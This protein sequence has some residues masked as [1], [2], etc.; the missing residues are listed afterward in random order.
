[1]VQ[2]KQLRLRA[3]LSQR[4]VAERVGVSQPHYQRW[5]TG[6]AEVPAEK[7]KRLALVL[8]AK[9]EQI[10]TKHMPKQVH[11][12]PLE[13]DKVP[14]DQSYYGEVSVH[15]RSGK[16]LVLSISEAA[17]SKIYRDMQGGGH[18]VCV[19]SL[20]NQ[21]VAI[22]REAITDLHLMSEA[23]DTYGPEHDDYDDSNMLLQLIDDR[24]W[25]IIERMEWDDNLEEEFDKDEV[26]RVAEILKC[27]TDDEFANLVAY[28]RIQPEDV[29]DYKANEAAKL[30]TIFNFSRNVRY[31]FSTGKLRTLSVDD[32]EALYDAT[33]AIF[34]DLFDKDDPFVRLPMA[35]GYH[36]V[37]FINLTTVDYISVPNHRFMR[38][39]YEALEKEIEEAEELDLKPEQV[40][41][42]RGR[43]PKN[44]DA[45]A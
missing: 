23:A 33:Y 27:T 40:K 14:D 32:D 15:F 19:R 26:A 24:S 12:Y 41:G 6:V 38:G 42:N 30:K 4:K 9:P 22:R 16:P 39:Y 2:L 43:R 25:E 5:E 7:V 1:M 31:Q 20:M 37:A 35:G 10:Q 11:L 36:E 13:E 45:G 17:F 28:G 44:D 18:F 29:E 3:G 8:K 21:L 34:D